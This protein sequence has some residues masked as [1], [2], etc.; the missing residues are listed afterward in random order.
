MGYSI[1]A[2]DSTAHGF[3][4]SDGIFSGYNL[5]GSTSTYIYGLNDLGDFSGRFDE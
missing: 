4:L 3:L 2:S 5:P 1:R